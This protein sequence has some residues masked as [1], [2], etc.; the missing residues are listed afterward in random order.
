MFYAC[1]GS[2][3]A[4]TVLW[5]CVWMN[6]WY[7]CINGMSVSC[8]G[9]LSL[10]NG[11]N[12][13]VNCDSP[14]T[15]VKNSEFQKLQ[16]KHAVLKKKCILHA[17]F[18]QNPGLKWRAINWEPSRQLP[19]FP[20][21]GISAN[22]AQRYKE[23]KNYLMWPTGLCKHIECYFKLFPWQHN[24]KK[25]RTNLAL[26]YGFFFFYRRLGETPSLQK[27]YDSMT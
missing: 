3:E 18:S 26:L 5:H 2:L 7:K 8:C 21:V 10:P 11:I 23:P 20:G 27:E 1:Q 4:W 25:D 13:H 16:K 12:A 19:I 9:Q 24:Q 17:V 6:K 14:Y 15:K 22:S